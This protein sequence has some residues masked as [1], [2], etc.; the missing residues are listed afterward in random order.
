MNRLMKNTNEAL[1]RDK[2]RINPANS[3]PP[4]PKKKN[5]QFFLTESGIST[6]MVSSKQN[7]ILVKN[8]KYHACIKKA[9]NSNIIFNKVNNHLQSSEL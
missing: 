2:I 5:L 4:P 7:G 6:R 1:I 9:T 8:E 3:Y